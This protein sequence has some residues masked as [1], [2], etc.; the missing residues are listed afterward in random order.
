MGRVSTVLARLSAF[1]SNQGPTH[2]SDLLHG[3]SS[4]VAVFDRC[5]IATDARQK[6][7]FS[8][9]QV[10]AATLLFIKKKK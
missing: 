9:G 8:H 4:S 2:A 5:D 10:V 6:A 7:Y 1:S 3:D